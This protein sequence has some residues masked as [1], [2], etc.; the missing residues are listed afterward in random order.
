MDTWEWFGTF[1]VA[2]LLDFI[3]GYIV[4]NQDSEARKKF[5]KVLRDAVRDYSETEEE[6]AE[7][8]RQEIREMVSS[9]KF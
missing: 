9:I 3:H 5:D 4:E 1:D 8:R 6:R 2:F 7:R